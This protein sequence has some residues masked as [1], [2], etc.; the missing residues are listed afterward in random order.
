MFK[1]VARG[2]VRPV[3]K[4]VFRPTVL[5]RASVPLTGPVLFASNHLSFMDS[6]AITLLAPR[7]VRFLAKSEYFTGTGAKGRASK[8]FFESI[9]AIPVDRSSTT[10]AQDSLDRGR[11]VLEASGAFA[12]YPEGTRSRDGRLYKG[13]T[14]VA[15][16]AL[17]TGSPIVPVALTGTQELLPVD[18]TVPRIRPVTVQF[19]EPIDPAPYGE[20]GSAR[21]RRRLTDDVMAAIGSMSGQE[22]AGAYNEP[23]ATTV[24]ER[25]R[26]A[27][28]RNDPE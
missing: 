8:L 21:A 1:T 26:R 5:G 17:T 16:L 23:P 3:S 4:V 15:W 27:L 18:A 20:A 28:H 14:G 25:V 2:L 9:G 10:A 7:D 24:V 13:R 11:E 6:V 19:G 22:L 12:I